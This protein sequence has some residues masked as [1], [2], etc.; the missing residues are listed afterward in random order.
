MSF[1]SERI[2]AGKRVADVMEF[3][4][5]TDVTIYYWESGVS[6]P[7][8]SRLLKLAEFYGCTVDDLLKQDDSKNPV[9]KN[10]QD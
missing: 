10:G 1:K 2:K 7:R 8:A 5:V 6:R 4:G 9:P 3:M